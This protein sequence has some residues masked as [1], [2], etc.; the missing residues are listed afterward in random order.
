[1]FAVGY[2]EL[3]IKRSHL[4]AARGEK[5]HYQALTVEGATKIESQWRLR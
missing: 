1:M 5:N 2:N 4:P 3:R